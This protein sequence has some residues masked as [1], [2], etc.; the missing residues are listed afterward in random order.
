[1]RE[2]V[3]CGKKKKMVKSYRKLPSRVKASPLGSTSLQMLTCNQKLSIYTF[4][5]KLRAE[6]WQPWWNS[7]SL[8]GWQRET[9]WYMEKQRSHLQRRAIRT[10]LFYSHHHGMSS[11]HLSAPWRVFL[12][13]DHIPAHSPVSKSTTGGPYPKCFKLAQLP[14]NP[15]GGEDSLQ[16]TLRLLEKNLDVD[17]DRRRRACLWLILNCRQ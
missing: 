1:M 5:S 17:F 15:V 7:S 2:L 12:R 6:I 9:L 10:A 3:A 16:R 11:A 4:Q 14:R 8:Q 13:T